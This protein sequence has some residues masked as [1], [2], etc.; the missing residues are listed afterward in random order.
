MVNVD[1]ASTGLGCVPVDDQR[2]SRG[3]LLRRHG[4]HQPTG[5]KSSGRTDFDQIPKLHRLA[6]ASRWFG[7][8]IECAA[9]QKRDR[10][11]RKE[12][13]TR[14]VSVAFWAMDSEGVRGGGIGRMTA[15][16]PKRGAGVACQPKMHSCGVRSI[17]SCMNEKLG[18]GWLSVAGRNCLLRCAAGWLRRRFRRLSKGAICM[19]AAALVLV[20]AFHSMPQPHTAPQ[21]ADSLAAIGCGLIRSKQA[22]PLRLNYSIAPD[23]PTESIDQN[24]AH[25]T[26]PTTH[27]TDTRQTQ[28]RH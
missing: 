2:Q 5:L 6:M 21:P 22:R 11:R 27:T 12:G 9:T 3:A 4:T 25:P 17:D 15:V 18:V 28:T 23:R 8:R 7:V 16:G 24:L 1:S 14:A 13:A 26:H 20:R 10:K 19:H